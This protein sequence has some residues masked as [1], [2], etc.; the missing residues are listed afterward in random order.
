LTIQSIIDIWESTPQE[1]KNKSFN[2]KEK[3]VMARV[4]L[5]FKRIFF[6]TEGGDYEGVQSFLKRG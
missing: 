5:F 4:S 3:E 6:K 1:E 2:V